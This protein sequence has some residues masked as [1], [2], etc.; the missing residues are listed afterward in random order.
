LAAA[1]LAPSRIASAALDIAVATD[2]S[3][4]AGCSA[5]M[6]ASLLTQFLDVEVKGWGSLSG[7]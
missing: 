3:G 6:A 2:L 5:D 1:S 7:L 4:S